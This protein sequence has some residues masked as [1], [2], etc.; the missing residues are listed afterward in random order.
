MAG[1]AGWLFSFLGVVSPGQ[2]D[3]AVSL[4][5]LVMVLVGGINTTLGPIVGAMFVTMFPAVVNIDP[6]LQEILYG[7]L[8]IFAITVFPEGVVGLAKRRLAAL[9]KTAA[10]RPC[11][12][13]G[14]E[15]ERRT[16]AHARQ[17]APANRRRRGDAEAIVECRGIDFGY[18]QG[19]KVL[20]KVDLAV[21]RGH[22][23]GLIGPNGSG[24]STLANIIA[25][26]LR[27]L[28]GTTHVKGVLVDG[29]APSARAKLGLRRTFQAAQLVREL[30]TSRNVVVG[31]Y[32]KVPGIVR[33]AA[34]W[35]MLPSGR[36]DGASMQSR[37]RRRCARSARGAGSP[38][39]SATCPM[40]SSS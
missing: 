32:G 26:R 18:G 8:S 7:A 34:F 13:A 11:E 23:H 4:N 20:R 24:K 12:P 10:A 25:G 5:I 29:L 14:A 37:P 16:V 17:P 31:L 33:R 39:G 3:W 6:W 35:P 19:P 30:T 9:F 36:R 21:K 38:A 1:G 2:F 27:P 15:R 40:V 22:I 28:A